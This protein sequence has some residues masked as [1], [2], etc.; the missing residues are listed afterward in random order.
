[1]P[2]IRVHPTGPMGSPNPRAR[3]VTRL[4]NV[5]VRAPSTPPPPTLPTLCARAQFTDVATETLVMLPTDMALKTDPI[6]RPI[7]QEYA[8]RQDVFFKDFSAAFAVRD[9]PAAHAARV[10]SCMRP[11]TQPPESLGAAH[12]MSA[13]LV[14][15]LLVPCLPSDWAHA[16]PALAAERR[17]TCT[18]SDS[19]SRACARR[20]WSPTAA[21]P[22]ASPSRLPR[23]HGRWRALSCVSWPCTARWSICSGCATRR[24]RGPGCARLNRSIEPDA[25]PDASP[26]ESPR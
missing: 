19:L 9:A 17:A 11:Q 20:N 8:D 5:P 3:R 24:N 6:F 21:R 22:N 18:C 14:P 25:S 2:P 15:R 12:P 4:A 23:A 7:A 13:L 16:R 1:M 10:A 26:N